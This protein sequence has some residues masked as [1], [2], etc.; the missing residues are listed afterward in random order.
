MIRLR[1]MSPKS[2]GDLGSGLAIHRSIHTPPTTTAPTPTTVQSA[3]DIVLP[4]LLNDSRWNADA[5]GHGRQVG[6]YDTSSSDHAPATN[7]N[8]GSNYNIRPEPYIALDKYITA[9]MSLLPNRDISAVEA[10]VCRP[11]NDIGAKE[12]IVPN[13]DS[14][15]VRRRDEDV[16]IERASLADNE[17]ATLVRVE[18]RSPH[19]VRSP[20][21]REMLET[22]HG[23]S[24]LKV[25]SPRVG[26]HKGAVCLPAEIS[27]SGFGGPVRE[28]K[29]PQIFDTSNH[30]PNINHHG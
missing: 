2:T 6:R 15:V 1:V 17:P 5:Q 25:E 24:R 7:P 22:S 12:H 29:Q 3:A 26:F 13:F 16:V 21:D 28:K 8:T 9:D 27:S 30:D 19:D 4:S 23:A 10:M 18:S 14:P 20:T 11:Q